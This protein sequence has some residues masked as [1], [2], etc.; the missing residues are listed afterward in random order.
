M[1]WGVAAFVVINPHIK[2][3]KVEWRIERMPQL[4]L[5]D[6]EYPC[7]AFLLETGGGEG[8]RNQGKNCLG[9]AKPEGERIGLRGSKLPFCLGIPIQEKEK[10]EEKEN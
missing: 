5:L 1:A 2:E 10:E 9:V 8:G 6:C 7:Y 4:R 3:H